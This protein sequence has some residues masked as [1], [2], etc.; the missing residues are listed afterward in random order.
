METLDCEVEDVPEYENH[1]RLESETSDYYDNIV[2]QAVHN[3]QYIQSKL[4]N[5][6]WS[7]DPPPRS[8]CLTSANFMGRKGSPRVKRK[9]KRSPRT[10]LGTDF[11]EKSGIVLDLKDKRWYF[12]VKPHHKIYF[13]EDLDV[14]SLQTA[15]S[16]IAKICHLSEDVGTPLTPEQREKMS[17]LLEKFYIVFRPGGDPTP[18]ME[19]HVNT[20]EHPLVS[21][22]P[23]RMSPMKKELLRKEIEDLLEKDVIEECESAYEL[24]WF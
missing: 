1:T 6:S 23:Y 4:Q 8:S 16:I 22:P 21:Q 2:T 20:E 9:E 17:Y 15:G 7:L 24:L 12:S 13:K 5:M 10:L 19:P 11:L 18:F 14:N 3:V